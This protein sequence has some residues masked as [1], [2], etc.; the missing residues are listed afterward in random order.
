MIKEDERANDILKNKCEAME[1]ILESE[2]KKI[3]KEK[4]RVRRCESKLNQ[5]NKIDVTDNELSDE[6]VIPEVKTSNRFSTLLSPVETFMDVDTKPKENKIKDSS[7]QT[8]T[9][10]CEEFSILNN[11]CC[12]LCDEKFKD[13]C[14]LRKHMHVKHLKDKG[15][16]VSFEI[17]P[18]SPKLK[19]DNY[20]CYYCAKILKSEEDLE[21]HSAASHEQFLSDF[22]CNKCGEKC[23][24]KADL[25]FH[26]F[27]QHGP[28]A[29]PSHRI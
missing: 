22:Y 18:T 9:V 27:S 29:K 24:D 15:C 3:K 26:K 23:V 11:Q 6:E 20:Q 4:Q 14:D 1:K 16:Q 28:F 5:T 7:I 2:R 8:D 10:K 13:I 17:I 25:G 21:G 19:F 12:E